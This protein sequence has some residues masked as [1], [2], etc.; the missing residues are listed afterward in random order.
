MAA[1]EYRKAADT[2]NVATKQHTDQWADL[3]RAVRTVAWSKSWVGDVGPH[4]T[5]EEAVQVI[6][7]SC[8]QVSDQTASAPFDWTP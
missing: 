8:S 7:N 6:R 2:I 5:R 3:A 4:L 1:H